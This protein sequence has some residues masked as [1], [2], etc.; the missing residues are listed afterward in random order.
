MRFSGIQKKES[1]LES[2]DNQKI[3]TLIT[4]TIQEDFL[5]IQIESLRVNEQSQAL[6]G[7]IL[8][9]ILVFLI[10]YT[11]LFIGCL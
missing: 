11:I 8:E 2:S 6:S 1:L 4:D 7:T 9:I 10:S 5:T 3:T